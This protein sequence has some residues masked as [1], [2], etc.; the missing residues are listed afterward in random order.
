V[1]KLAD[2]PAARASHLA[3]RLDDDGLPYAFGGALALGAW[4]L[5]RTTADVDVS[6]FAPETELEAVLDAVERAG[7][8]V[9]RDAARGSVARLGM[10]VADLGGTRIDVFIAHHPMHADMER[11]RVLLETPDG[12]RRWFL[13]A[14][15]VVLTKMIYAR[16]KDVADL[17][18]LFAV[19]A[20]RLDLPY[21][22]AWLSRIVPAEDR[23][24]ALFAALARAE[25]EHRRR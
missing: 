1:S 6:V 21:V 17:E 14:E 4:G 11:R 19:Q 12:K 5:P 3:D 15:D 23:R 13:S 8:I 24:H 20:G 10:F 22:S 7:A 25:E 2:A 9:D 16:P 18:R